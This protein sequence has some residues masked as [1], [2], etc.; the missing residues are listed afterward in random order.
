MPSRMQVRC[1][2]ST[3]RAVLCVALCAQYRLR[4]P[5][6]MVLRYRDTQIYGSEGLWILRYLDHVSS[7]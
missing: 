5:S 3:L 7:I 6:S 1:W 4:C 2:Y